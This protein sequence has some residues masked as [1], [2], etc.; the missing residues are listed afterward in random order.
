MKPTAEFFQTLGQ[1]VYQYKDSEESIYYTGK[2]NGDRCL[3]HVKD[4]D[5]DMNEC[6]IIARNLE[7]F[8]NKKDWQSFLLESFLIS[9]DNPD[10]NSVSGHYK[11]CFV[12]S[13]LLDIC[14]EWQNNQYDNFEKFPDWYIKHYDTFR[15]KVRELK[16]NQ[17]TTFLISNA[18]NATYLMFWWYPNLNNSIKVTFEINQSDDRLETTKESLIKWL[19]SIGHKKVHRESNLKKVTIDL[20][21]IEE[22]VG[23]FETFWKVP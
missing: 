9:K 17:T 4:K 19:G 14:A 8:E 22:V 23:L 11:E 2:G 10:V 1:Y 15:G 16:I 20:G 7:K 12:Q 18:R 6:Y 5:F 21:T 13:K 3:S